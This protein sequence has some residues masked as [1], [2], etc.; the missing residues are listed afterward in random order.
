MKRNKENSKKRV[1]V[2]LAVILF[3][4]AILNVC[5]EAVEKFPSRPIEFVVCYPPGGGADRS[6]RLV[7]P[8]IEKILGV[9][10]Y[11]TNKAG[12]SGMVG[13]TYA[14]NKKPDGYTIFGLHQYSTFVAGVLGELPYD[15][16]DIYP[17]CNWIDNINLWAVQTKS[18]FKTIKELVEYAKQNPGKL[19]CGVP[20]TR[21]SQGV[22][23]TFMMWYL[24]ID[25]VPVPFG[26]SGPTLTG[27]LGGHVDLASIP[28][29]MVKPHVQAGKLRVLVILGKKKIDEL[30]DVPTA[31]KLGYEA[32]PLAFAGAAISARVPKDRI[33]IISKAFDKAMRDPEV[34]GRLKKAGFVPVYMDHEKFAKHIED[35]Y[36]KVEKIK[37]KLK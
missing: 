28:Y 29:A 2:F 17:I 12:G 4:L 24:G 25:M 37:D 3:G 26:G 30:P 23:A 15:L 16:K 1:L 5:A 18:R 14:L 22:G 27:L 31:V 20:S 21:T 8:A 7:M 13:V 36:A 34:L 32:E 9:P 11:I 19:K 35:G 33:E 10:V 6:A